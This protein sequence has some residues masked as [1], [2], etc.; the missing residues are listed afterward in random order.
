MAEVKRGNFLVRFFYPLFYNSGGMFLLFFSVLVEMRRLPRSLKRLF[1]QMY[2]IGVNT[3]PLALMIGLFTGMI[4]AL[5]T[6][7]QLK[8]YNM[9]HI[10]GGIV[11]LSL[12]LEMGPVITSFIV[13][14]RVGAAMAAELGTMSVSEEVDALKTLG[15]NPVERLA[16]AAR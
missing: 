11:G 2:E 14:G 16:L 12:I 5:Q 10:V 3:L 4:V 15:I 8:M 1:T 6:G 9:Q 13:T 7:T